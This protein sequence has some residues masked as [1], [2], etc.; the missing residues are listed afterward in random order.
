VSCPPRALSHSTIRRRDVAAVERLG[1]FRAEALD[2]V[3]EL[4]LVER[5]ALA[6]RA[7]GGGEHGA[8]LGRGEQDRLEDRCDV[9][10]LGVDRHAVAGE[11]RGRRGELGRGDAAPALERRGQARRRAVGP[12][13]GGADVEDLHH[14]AE[15]HLGRQ[16]V[17][18]LGGVG[19]APWRL[20]EEVEQRRLLARAGDEQVAAGARAGE[21]RLGDPRGQHRRDGRVDGVAAFAQHARAGLGGDRVA[22]GDHAGG[23]GAHG[24]HDRPTPP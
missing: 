7:A 8:D 9:G 16:Q 17:G 3:A 10:L 19:A 2:R 23:G 21:Q 13:R 22:G 20:D 14:V 6:Q 12:A 11:P 1:A 5:L 18:A 4:R 15:G 24:A